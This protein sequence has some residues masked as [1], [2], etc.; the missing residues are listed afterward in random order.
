MMRGE[1]FQLS[2][3]ADAAISLYGKLLETPLARAAAEKLYA[4]LQE[5]DRDQEADYIFKRYLG[6]CRH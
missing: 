3:D 4:L 6:T 5:C 2:G 1:V